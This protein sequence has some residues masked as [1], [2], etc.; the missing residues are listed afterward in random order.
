[1]MG[2]SPHPTDAQLAARMIRDARCPVALTGAG[3]STA[4]GIPDFR[5]AG[6]GL[7]A[8]PDAM[9]VASLTAFRHDPERFFEAIRPLAARLL[10]ARPNPAHHALAALEQAG[11]LRAVVTQN[12]DDLHRQAGSQEVVELHGSFR[13]ATCTGCFTSRRTDEILEQWLETSGPPRCPGCGCILKPDVI[14]F[15]E[16]LPHAALERALG[17]VHSCDLCLVVGS[18]LEVNPAAGLPYR[19]LCSGAR[20]II[21]N[22]Q[23]TYLDRR[24]S[25]VF[26]EEAA[27]VLALLVDEVL[28]DR[29]PA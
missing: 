28:C 8:S 5:S 15:E 2:R 22:R 16:Q 18:S 26:R 4:S 27:D 3:I 23:P 1:M 14:L 13:H 21:V 24:A 19:A 25:L 7:W 11:R 20:L 10:E 12:V 17:W 9:A 29:A 6:S